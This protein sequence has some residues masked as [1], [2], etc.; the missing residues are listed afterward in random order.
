MGRESEEREGNLRRVERGE[1]ERASGGGS[2]SH[3]LDPLE[4]IIQDPIRLAPITQRMPLAPAAP[5]LPPSPAGPPLPPW[6]PPPPARAELFK[7]GGPLGGG[8]HSLRAGLALFASAS[9]VRSV[10][11]QTPLRRKGRGPS[12][13]G[14]RPRPRS[15][16]FRA[17]AA[18]AFAVSLVVR[19]VS[20]LLGPRPRRGASPGLGA[21]LRGCGP[22]ALRASAARVRRLRAASAPGLRRVVAPGASGPV[23]VVGLSI[24]VVFC[25]VP[26]ARGYVG[27]KKANH[28]GVVP[29]GLLPAVI[30]PVFLAVLP[31]GWYPC[32]PPPLQTATRAISGQLCGDGVFVP[33]LHRLQPG[34][35]LPARRQKLFYAAFVIQNFNQQQHFFPGERGDRT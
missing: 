33:V 2:L 32:L 19:R 18:A 15:L 4:K 1:S 24:A 8:G 21:A 3:S 9:G 12:P 30:F 23:L 14:L 20:L 13:R 16:F 27:M 10:G 26:R 35:Y 34:I 22:F 11:P 17:P 31:R 29:S 25:R 7:K 28:G 6:P 5:L